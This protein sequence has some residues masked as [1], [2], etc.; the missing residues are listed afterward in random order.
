MIRSKDEKRT[1]F[2]SP[3]SEADRVT[4]RALIVDVDNFTA[5]RGA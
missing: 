3:A 2:N 5:G 1:S 4:R